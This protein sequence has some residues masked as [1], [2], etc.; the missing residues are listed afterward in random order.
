MAIAFNRRGPC[1]AEPWIY[2]LRSI[3]ILPS[4]DV[5][6]IAGLER[7]K[8]FAIEGF[9]YESWNKYEVLLYE[10]L[11]RRPPLP[12]SFRIDI[13]ARAKL[14]IRVLVAICGCGA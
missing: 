4:V 3:P 11:I 6:D 7:L 1:S 10:I 5:F 12:P 13:A 2:L 9:G 8:Q 14:T